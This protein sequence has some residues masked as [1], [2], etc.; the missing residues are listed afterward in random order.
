MQMIAKKQ[1]YP[2]Q[3]KGLYSN[4]LSASLTQVNQ[5]NPC[6]YWQHER[7]EKPCQKPDRI[8]LQARGAMGQA[9]LPISTHPTLAIRSAIMR[10][11]IAP[12]LTTP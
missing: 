7:R 9:Q 12:S 4:P 11:Q 1:I 3:V 5:A 2:D 8:L 6:R 10:R